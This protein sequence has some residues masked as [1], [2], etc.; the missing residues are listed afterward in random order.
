MHWLYLFFSVWQLYAAPEFTS[1]RE[2]IHWISAENI[3]SA[4]QRESRPVLVYIHTSW[5]GWCRKMER[6]TF[7]KV[8]LVKY[9]NEHYHAVAFDGEY[10]HPVTF[11]GK[12]YRYS[13]AERVHELTLYLTR[14]EPAFPVVVFLNEP[15]GAPNP[16]AGYL[17]AQQLEP[18]LKYFKEQ[19]PVSFENYLKNFKPVW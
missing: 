14:G 8:A 7:K 4:V 19:P 13:A 9:V 1:Q 10:K 3:E 2:R 15:K 6:S 5:C 11:N 16:L 17:T 12:T 18:A